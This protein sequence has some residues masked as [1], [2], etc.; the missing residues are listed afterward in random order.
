MALLGA[1]I[2]YME[3]G[4]FICAMVL[5]EDSKRLRL[6]NQ[7]GRE[8]NLP[9]SRVLHQSAKR[10]ALSLNR[11]EQLR[12]LKEAD[13]VRQA[14]V[15]QIDL[16]EIWQLASEEEG[17]NFSPAFLAELAFGEDATDNHVAA[18]LRSIFVDRLYF[19]YKEGLVLAHSPEAVA[20]L[21]LKQEREREQEALM[22]T[23]AMG[24]KHLWEGESTAV[25]EERDRCLSLLGDYYLFGSEAEESELAR[26]LLKK[27]G[28][29]GPH[30]VYH[31]LIKAG[32]WQAHENVALLRY[33]IPVDFSEEIA[34]AAQVSEPVAEELV[35]RNRRD[36]RELPL[37]TIDGESTRDY[38]DALHIERRGDNFLVGIH[39]SD[40]AHYVAPG[41]P[42]YEEAARRMTSL[43]FPET[44]IPMLP[45]SLSEGVCSLVAG[46]ARA[47]VSA[48]V[49]LSPQ[50]EVVEF[51]LIP[52][53]VTVKRQLSYPE[54][55]RLVAG[56]DWELQTLARLSEQ[57]KQRRIEKGALLLPVPDVNIS[58]DAE[59]KV[60]VALSPVDTIS[61][62]LVAEFMVLANTLSA[63]FVADR[64]AP[65]LFRAQDEPHQRLIG[66]GEKDLFSIFRQRK[67]LKP[68]ELLVYPKPH[69]GVGAMQYTTVTSPIRRFLDL[70]MQHQI[71]Q[72]LSG[73]GAMFSADELAGVAGDIS[74]VLSKVNQVR[75][76]RHR[77]WLLRYLEQKVG[78]RIEALL[79]NKGPKRINLTLL[80]CL[81]DADMPPSQSVSAKPGDVTTVRVAKVDAL[82][83]V[84]R[85]EW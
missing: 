52:S 36:F 55:E 25:W 43:Y 66:G 56:G 11:D 27:A 17:G 75:R 38:D 84:L 12:L 28:L 54:A 41:T 44:Q 8:V 29:T 13:Q 9:L 19:K 57:L 10:H 18:F 85:L 62:S 70:V 68:G 46:K 14:M 76:T 49:L 26:E 48:M 20:A 74:K 82:D 39:I 37:L 53:L 73:R 35:G 30:D 64:Q 16:A 79:V 50:G 24:L 4:R 6:I 3:Q 58:I 21:R 80:D 22:S 63:Q 78:G 71:K 69:S 42:I 34:A 2:E 81:L 23:G 15:G 72:L 59:G 40:V 45:R 32:V 5:D 47:A 67:Q 31:L 1:I 60:A 65:G 61:R 33:R 7:N 51:D 77:Y 83:N